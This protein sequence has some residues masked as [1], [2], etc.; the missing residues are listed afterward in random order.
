M[1]LTIDTKECPAK[2]ILLRSTVTP[3]VSIA[4][5]CSLGA[6]SQR[7]TTNTFDSCILL[8]AQLP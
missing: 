6:S 5:R 2:I 7:Q 3:D 1:R 4:K 8:I